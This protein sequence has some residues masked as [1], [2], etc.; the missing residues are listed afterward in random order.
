MMNKN[1]MPPLQQ[2]DYIAEITKTILGDKR[3]VRNCEKEYIICKLNII[4]DSINVKYKNNGELSV[5]TNKIET[6]LKQFF[7]SYIDTSDDEINELK[8]FLRFWLIEIK[9]QIFLNSKQ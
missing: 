7:C 3:I 4:L 6:L 8:K 9:I 5:W 1:N 2:L